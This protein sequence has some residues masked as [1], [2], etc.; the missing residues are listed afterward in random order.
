MEL[1]LLIQDN[2]NLD[3]T[4]TAMKIFSNADLLLYQNKLDE[5]FD[6]LDQIVINY[7]GHSLVDEALFKQHEIKIKQGKQEDASELLDQI[8]TFFSYDIL[9]DDAKF[10]Q[11]QLQENY[12][13]NKEKAS[14]LYQEI[15][16]KHQDSFY[17]SESRKRYRKLRGE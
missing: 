10:L 16:S 6:A 3:T 8:I 11:A 1:S 5:A 17:V 14:E 15:I 7:Q 9:V 13:K 12:F 2:L 4:T